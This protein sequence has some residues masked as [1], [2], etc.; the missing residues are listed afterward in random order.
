M[1]TAI[2]TGASAGLGIEFA[3]LFVQ[4][5][6][7]VVLVAR[8]KEQ[9]EAVANSLKAIFPNSKAY[10]IGMDLGSPGAGQRLF[11]RTQSLGLK[12]DFLVNNAGFG[13]AGDFSKL[14]LSRQLQMIDLNVRTLV[15]LTH[16]YLPSMREN[17]FGRIL[18]VGSTAGFQ[19][20]PYMA[21]YFATKAFVNSFSEALHEELNGTGVT[22]TVLAPGATATEFQ[23]VAHLDKALLFKTGVASS[24]P[25]VRA[26]YIG[27]LAGKALVVPGFKNKFSVQLL[28]ISPRKMVRKLVARL[29]RA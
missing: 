8:R 26:G 1:G 20:G 9:L 13:E 28:R 14:S 11:E 3:K 17:K 2:V 16:L 23:S 18:N 24:G 6:H 10:V 5:G 7:Q 27:L 25:V 29:N 4:D 19:P 15:E 21:T 12:I 22:C